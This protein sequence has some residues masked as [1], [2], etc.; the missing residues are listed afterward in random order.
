[1]GLR[2]TIN[3]NVSAGLGRLA[4]NDPI[5]SKGSL[6]LL[7]FTHSAGSI[8][9]GIPTN[10][11]VAPN[12]ARRE[13]R[14]IIGAG[15]LTDMDWQVRT[16]AVAAGAMQLERTAKGGVHVAVAKNLG[17]G[18]VPYCIFFPGGPIQTYVH[19]HMENRQFYMSSWWTL[20]RS[21]ATLTGQSFFHKGQNTANF[22]F[23]SADG[24]IGPL[25]GTPLKGRY[26]RISNPSG[27]AT[28]ALLG[29]PQHT[30]VSMLGRTGADFPLTNDGVGQGFRG[31]EFG[32]GTFSAWSSANQ[33][34]APS[35]ILK[36]CYIEDLTAS[37]R[38]Y[39]QVLAIDQALHA[40]AHA[41]GG[42]WYEDTWTPPAELVG[43]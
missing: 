34:D 35:V 32:G 8:G 23:L 26:V 40:A 43:N 21:R 13:A 30:A 9:S 2:E 14:A 6:C 19:T 39:E 1:M 41:A 20:T 11:M 42:K 12:I 24:G 15:A 17:A 38:T 4:F 25:S 36:R 10:L 5:M 37:G 27:Y 33:A 31:I 29:Q 3:T 7:D 28:P 16:Q 22:L 18:I